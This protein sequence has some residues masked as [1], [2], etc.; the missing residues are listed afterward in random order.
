MPRYLSPAPAG[1]RP[2]GKPASTHTWNTAS[3][4]AGNCPLSKGLS[5]TRALGWEQGRGSACLTSPL[6]AVPS[7]STTASNPRLGR[8]RQSSPVQ[9]MQK[10]PGHDKQ[11]RMHLGDT[12]PPQGL[13]PE[14]LISSQ[15][16][17]PAPTPRRD[18][19]N[20]F[21]STHLTGAGTPL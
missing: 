11:P 15:C 3:H 8:K 9:P 4:P 12:A 19:P 21:P 7:P 5:K 18:H 10:G 14:D 2:G 13:S 17:N 16:A 20:A 6:G 1:H